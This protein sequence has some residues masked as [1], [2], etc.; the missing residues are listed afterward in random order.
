MKSDGRLE[1]ILKAILQ[2]G[3]SK[4]E[5]ERRLQ[6]VI[7]D[8][9]SGPLGKAADMA[10]VEKCQSLL[11]TLKT[12]GSLPY[13]DHALENKQK[14]MQKLEEKP[15]KKRTNLHRVIL[16]AAA[17]IAVLGLGFAGLRWIR[18][19]SNRDEQQYILRS[20]EISADVIEKSVAA[21]GEE[22]NFSTASREEAEAYL[23][24]Q[25]PLPS[26]LLGE[27]EISK[28]S[29]S[30][31]PYWTECMVYY[32]H[33][34]EYIRIKLF[35][36]ADYNEFKLFFEQNEKGTNISLNGKK[37]YVSENK[38]KKALTWIENNVVYDV[39]QIGDLEQGKQ[40]FNEI[41]RI[42]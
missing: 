22:C 42:Q 32:S 18:G 10:L 2:E 40:I 29:I 31:L 38:G 25:I 14:L 9:L 21:H 7:D 4:K 39:F 13:E 15:E 23:G 8:E 16:A 1:T 20:S 5:A 36:V 17:L 3:L 6:T 37:V 11:W 24:F 41:R 19:A 33:N 26:E 35:F 12:N 34:D 30:I 28:L 27:Y